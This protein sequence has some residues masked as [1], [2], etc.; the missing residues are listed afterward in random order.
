MH[1]AR[2]L[3]AGQ[4]RRLR[5]ELESEVEERLHNSGW[6]NR[7]AAVCLDPDFK[8]KGPGFRHS[9]G[10]NPRIVEPEYVI[11]LGALFSGV[12]LDKEYV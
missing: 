12:L 7:V 10:N 6:G 5:T 9:Y 3:W 11:Y 2:G 1:P 4:E 8:D